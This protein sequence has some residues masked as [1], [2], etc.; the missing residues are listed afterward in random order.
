MFEQAILSEQFQ[1]LLFKQRQ[2]ADAYDELLRSAEDPELRSQLD[3]ICRQKLRDIRMS[4]RLLEIV[5]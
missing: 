3:E 1:Q 5:P 2:I 4:E